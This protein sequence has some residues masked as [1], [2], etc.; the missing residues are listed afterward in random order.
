MTTS[1]GSTFYVQGT[2][3]DDTFRWDGMQSYVTVDGGSGTDTLSLAIAT[4][5]REINLYSAA[6]QNIEYLM[7]SSLNDTLRGGSLAENLAGGDGADTIATSTINS[8]DYVNFSSINGAQIG[9]ADISSTVVNGNALTITLAS[10]DSL[11]VANWTL[12]DGSK[13]NKFTFG[14]N[15]TYSLALAIDNTP[16]WTKLD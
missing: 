1:S 6:Y 12:T 10:G 5:G 9:G 13:L 3:L 16:T 11:T 15:G 4:V 7:G 14:A 2:S 8:A